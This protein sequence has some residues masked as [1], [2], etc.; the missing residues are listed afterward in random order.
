MTQAAWPALI[1]QLYD[2]YFEQTAAYFGAKTGC[3]PLHILWDQHSNLV[4][5]ANNTVTNQNGLQADAWIY[6]LHSRQRS[7]KSVELRAPATGAYDCFPLEVPDRIGEV[8]FAKLKLSRGNT[9]LSDNFYWSPTDDGDC[10]ALNTLP[11]VRL[12]CSATLATEGSDH[13]VSATASNP[14][15]SVELAIR[16]KLV[17]GTSG[18]RVLPAMYEENYFSLVPGERKTVSIRFAGA[19]L[20]GEAARLVLEGWNIQHSELSIE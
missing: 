15:V 12:Q 20:A 19:A 17:R 3:Q 18:Q 6:D 9:V 10:H 2:Y 14:S 1:C 11:L 16:L 8:F 7:H 13:I 5:V 4:K